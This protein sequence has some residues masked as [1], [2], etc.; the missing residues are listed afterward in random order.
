MK[1]YIVQLDNHD[2]VISARDKISWSKATRVLLVWPRRGRVLE[3][4][5]DLLLL[6]RH[7]QHSGAQLA[8]VTSDSQVRTNAGELGIP[9]FS[10]AEDA[11]KVTWRR[12]RRRRRI[13]LR[14]GTRIDPHTLRPQR[15]A[16][17]VH[18]KVGQKTRLAAFSIGVVAVIALVLFFLPTAQIELT[19]LRTTQRLV[20]PMWASPALPAASSSGGIPAAE[21]VVVVEG[22][23][24]AAVTGQ[25]RVADASAAGEVRLTNLT[26]QPVIVPAGS[27]VMT[28]TAPVVRFATTQEARIPAGPGQQTVVEIEALVPG[29]A[30]NVAAGQIRAM[31]GALGLRL[32]VENPTAIR[33]GSERV[34]PSPSARDYQ[35]LRE[36]L[37]AT[38][39]KTAQDEMIGMLQ[40]GQRLLDETVHVNEVIEEIAEPAENQPGDRLVLSMRVQFQ[41]MLVNE[42]DLIQVAQA[43]LDANQEQGYQPVP[44]SLVFAFASTP[45]F[46]DPGSAD[47]SRPATARW[48]LGIERMLEKGLPEAS[49]VRAVQG[50][51]ITEA[52]SS[53]QAR[54]SLIE[55]PHIRI[56][57][58][59]WPRMPF[60][61]FRIQ[62]VKP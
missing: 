55:P 11:Q 27:V 60:L 7:A 56:W 35:T 1:T 28:T 23:D 21:M 5:I 25:G 54:L 4:R 9:I 30:G 32:V 61:P 26:D 36:K 44:G 42:A 8:V 34:S 47:G 37:L 51:A 40:T 20:I 52:S 13:P 59:W 12:E 14:R 58:S 2:D 17:T 43:A 38:L 15:D 22:R 48:D 45:R 49:I 10:Q 6:K 3:R 33:G 41:A 18:E 50:R 31:E 62:V 29:I 39:R 57:P 16:L 24:E 46:D 19:P 53:L